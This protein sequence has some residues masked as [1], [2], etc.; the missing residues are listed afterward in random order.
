M[1][2]NQVVWKMAK[3]HYK[4]YLFYFVCNTLAVMFFFMFMTIY[5]NEQLVAV[6]KIEG[7]Q[8]VLAIPGAALVMFTIFFISY[9]HHI[10]MKKR[11]SEFGLFMTLGMT[12]RDISKLLLLENSIIA[13]AAIVIGN[14]SC[15]IFYQFFFWFLLKSAVLQE[16]NFHINANMFIYSIGAFMI[17]F[18]VSI[19]KSLYVTMKR[20]IIENLKTE[21]VTENRSY[22]NPV[23][24]GI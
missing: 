9:A 15:S 11:R 14:G 22:K 7:L 10:F 5:L 4:K 2:F 24:G 17:V 20:D 21:K 1:T 6:K 8:Y 16:I 23:I 19:A 3:Y 18:I 13:L 12:S